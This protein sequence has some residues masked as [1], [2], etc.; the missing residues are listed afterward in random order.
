MKKLIATV[1]LLLVLLVQPVFGKCIV[2]QQR[3]DP[4][5]TLVFVDIDCNGWVDVVEVWKWNGQ[6]WILV[7]V[8]PY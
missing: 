1:L 5:T 8:R 4:Y 6:R 7:G 3:V 2:N